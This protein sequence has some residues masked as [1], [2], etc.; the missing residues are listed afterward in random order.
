MA[1]KQQYKLPFTLDTGPLDI[2]INLSAQNSNMSFSKRPVTV[3]FFIMAAAAAAAWF[4]IT[5][6]SPLAHGSVLSLV[7]WS[8]SY[9]AVVGMML[10]P[11]K[12]KG[13]GY[14]WFMPSIQ[15]LFKV[16]RHVGTKSV[17]ATGPVH[18]LLDLNQV[19]ND[20]LL[21]FDNGDVGQ[22]LN[23]VGFG[24]I[25]MFDSD[26]DQVLAD[27]NK[28]Y[29]NLPAGAVVIYDTRQSPQKVE[30]QIHNLKEQARNREINSKALKALQKNE[31]LTLRQYVGQQF[32]STHQVMIIRT[33]DVE[34]LQAFNSQ[35][36]TVAGG[37]F[38]RS[39]EVMEQEDVFEYMKDLKGS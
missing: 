36:A 5:F 25:L 11:T 22:I 37:S 34:H 16:N 26:R 14:D 7:L 12:T 10:A 3:K 30:T 38:I 19:K 15:Y 9:F 28:F 31:L 18:M 27:T 1:V 33:S 4:M 6:N 8:L 24:S 35:L 20:G 29:R 21:I 23:I 32:K 17:D 13:M 2:E 39:A